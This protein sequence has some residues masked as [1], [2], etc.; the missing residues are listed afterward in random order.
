MFTLEWNKNR[1]KLIDQ[2]L[3]PQELKYIYCRNATEVWSAIRSL[4][5]RGAPAIGIAAAFGVYLGVRNYRAKKYA[6]FKKNFIKCSSFIKTAR[7]TA[8]NLFWSLDRLE[9]RVKNNPQLAPE[10]LKK[11]VFGEAM[12][13]YNEDRLICRRLAEYGARLIHRGD[14]LLTYC[15]AGVLATVDYGTALGVI[16]M[17][18][19]RGKRV[20]VY[21]CETRPVLQGSRLTSW[22]LMQ[23]K[24]NVTLI[25]DNAAAF[26]MAK[27]KID[28]IFVG[29]DRIAAN[30]D[31]ANKIGTYNLA[32]CARYHKVP[33]YVVAPLS[34]FDFSVKDAKGI[35]IE[36]RSPDEVRKIK[37]VY[38]APKTVKVYNPA[39]DI[40]PA[41]LISA[42]VTEK[43]IVRRPNRRKLS[44]LNIR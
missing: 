17:A 24:V 30:G 26:L 41:E 10:I 4:K 20:K 16:Y 33:F 19:S 44:K 29:A 31:T 22:E 23:Q 43:G 7:P 14:T 28:K 5:V 42:I 37:N 12:T 35:P 32:V 3:L 18:K 21:A 11:I 34:T 1:L 6:D 8:V 40:T 13:I 39:F 15:N 27:G 2:R 36:Q 38:I 9:A 25:C